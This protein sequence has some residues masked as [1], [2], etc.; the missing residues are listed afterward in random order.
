[1]LPVNRKAQKV[2]RCTFCVKMGYDERGVKMHQLLEFVLLDGFAK[3]SFV[4][5]RYI[6][7]K[8]PKNCT[9]FVIFNGLTFC[10]L[11]NN[12]RQLTLWVGD[13][14]KELAKL[15]HILSLVY[16]LLAYR[17]FVNTDKNLSS[18]QCRNLSWR[19]RRGI[20]SMKIYGGYFTWPASCCAHDKPRH[21]NKIL[22]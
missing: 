11:W 15:T 9:I 1:M 10:G 7:V 22:T 17:S 21:S 20:G 14:K 16:T 13:S 5:Q 12:T 2:V 19:I 6:F 3:Q 4:W 18:L 8:M